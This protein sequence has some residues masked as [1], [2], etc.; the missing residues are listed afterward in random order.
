MQIVKM[1][2]EKNIII[3]RLFEYFSLVKEMHKERLERGELGMDMAVLLCRTAGIW[4]GLVRPDGRRRRA[5]SNV[6]SYT[7]R[8][9]G[10]KKIIN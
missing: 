5:A 10:E 2:R 4:F 9:W 1:K 3:Y 7:C 6:V 8:R